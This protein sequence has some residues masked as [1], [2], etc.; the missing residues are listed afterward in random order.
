[1]RPW[2]DLT[3]AEQTAVRLQHPD[4]MPALLE[5]WRWRLSATLGWTTWPGVD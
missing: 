2:Q 4:W 5:A 1:M 3:E